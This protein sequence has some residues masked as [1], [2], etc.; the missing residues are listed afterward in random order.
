MTESVH[1]AGP[2]VVRGHWRLRE[3]AAFPDGGPRTGD[4]S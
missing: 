2:Q 4:R 3:A 1:A